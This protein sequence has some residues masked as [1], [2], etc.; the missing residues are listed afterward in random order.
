M[1]NKT[2][3]L[4]YST[5]RSGKWGDF[6]LGKGTTMLLNEK[7]YMCCLG[8]ISLQL[9]VTKEQILDKA[10]PRNICEFTH[11]LLIKEGISYVG[12]T[13]I[14]NSSLAET[15]MNINDNPDTTPLEKIDKLTDL[16]AGEGYTLKTINLPSQNK[17][18]WIFRKL[19]TF[20]T[21]FHSHFM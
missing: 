6:Q 14:I 1:E 13:K 12:E 2:L 20:L 9:G 5:W 18:L 8:Q 17:L 16:F 3:I 11:P 21:F 7:G 10:T 19:K 15:A 4:D